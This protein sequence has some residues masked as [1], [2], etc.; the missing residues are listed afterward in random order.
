MAYDQRLMK[1]QPVLGR[2]GLAL[3]YGLPIAVVVVAVLAATDFR[4]GGPLISWIGIG[5][6][7]AVALFV[8]TRDKR[9]NG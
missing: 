3:S 6:A 1:R 8:M 2:F 9:P 7:S 4:P 5:V